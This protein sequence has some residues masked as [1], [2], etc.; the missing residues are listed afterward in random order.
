MKKLLGVAKVEKAYVGHCLCTE[1][2]ALDDVSPF[3]TCRVLRPLLEP[4]CFE[5]VL[6]QGA[7]TKLFGSVHL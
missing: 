4:T 1:G 6:K 5:N 7:F 2:S 3:F